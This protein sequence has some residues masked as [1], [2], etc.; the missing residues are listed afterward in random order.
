MKKYVF[1]YVLLIV[2]MAMTGYAIWQNNKTYQYISF[3]SYD[4]ERIERKV[5]E[6][7]QKVQKVWSLTSDVYL[8]V[9]R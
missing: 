1:L 4:N 5:G 8:K 9:D 7:D 6:L 2:N 3:V